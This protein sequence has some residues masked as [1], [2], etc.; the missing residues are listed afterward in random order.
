MYVT[1][2]RTGALRVRLTPFSEAVQAKHGMTQT[3]ATM[4]AKAQRKIAAHV[5]Q[6]ED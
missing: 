4:N 2:T 1:R 3:P 6:S 5:A